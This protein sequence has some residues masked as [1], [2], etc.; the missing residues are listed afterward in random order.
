M[1]ELYQNG[2]VEVDFDVYEVK[3]NVH[4]FAVMMLKRGSLTK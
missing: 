4:A 3:N 1:A 2:P